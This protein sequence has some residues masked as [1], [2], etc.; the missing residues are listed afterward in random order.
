MTGDPSKSIARGD[1]VARPGPSRMSRST[2]LRRSLGAAVLVAAPDI[3]TNT[4]GSAALAAGGGRS[5]VSRH[6]F[7]YGVADPGTIPGP[8]VEAATW[9]EGRN[10]PLA[11]VAT[12][13]AAVPVRSPDETRLALVALREHPVGWAVTVSVADT[14]SGAIV[15]SG[16]FTISGSAD[17]N[18]LVTPVFAADSSTVALVM[19]ITV[20]SNWRTL[21]KLNP[22]TGE[23]RLVRTATWTS[24]H[25]LAYF[26][27]RTGSLAG[28]YDLEDGP[29]LAR[30]TAAANDRDLFLWTMKEPAALRGTKDNP[31]PAPSPRLSAFPLGSGRA[32]YVVPASEVWPVNDEPLITLQSGKIA[33]LVNGQRLEMYSPESGAHSSDVIAPLADASA[34][35]A[36]VTMQARPDGLV[37][38]SNASRGRAVIAE[39][40]DSFKVRSVVSYPPPALPRGAP[41]SKAVLSADATTI[42]TLG[43]SDAGGLSAYSA[44]SGALVASQRNGK[45]YSGVYELPSR[46]VLAISPERPRLSFFSPSLGSLGAAETNLH[47]VEVY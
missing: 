3:F 24:T 29:S 6:F 7:L 8:S 34:K 26:D 22:V 40:G 27:S 38:I 21:T 17:A 32:R 23:A 47:V 20:P 31:A 46:M 18:V 28:P 10:S 13:L 9:A 16:E 19:S 5:P 36:Q 1:V 14:I 39:A 41:S 15:S 35:P 45:H 4:R 43:G 30:V 33:R 2:L 44:S 25:S 12:Q 11:T 37:F 42:Y